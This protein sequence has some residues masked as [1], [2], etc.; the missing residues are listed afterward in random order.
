MDDIDREP[1]LAAQQN[2]L[3][4]LLTDSSS[5]DA[6]ALALL[7]STVAVLLFI[8]QVTIDLAWFGWAALLSPFFV[9][10]GFNLAAVY[11]R[12]Y[13]P[14]SVNIDDH[15]EYLAMDKETLVLQLLSDTQNSIVQNTAL[16]AQRWRYCAIAFALTLIGSLVLLI[17]LGVQ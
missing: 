7:A 12:K 10:L 15:P 17:T 13:L 14:A 6:K 4:V 9:S 1:L 11:P 2:Q 16:N 3:G 8:G 5:I